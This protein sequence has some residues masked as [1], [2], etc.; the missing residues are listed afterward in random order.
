MNVF[1]NKL[2]MYYEI[3]K[4]FREDHTI[5]EI[6]RELVLNRRTVRSYLSMTEL[7]YEQ[8]ISNQSD[9]KKDLL[10]FEDFVKSRLEQFQDTST[11]QIHDWLKEK[12]E[13][14]P[15]VST[16]TIYNFVMWVRQK[17]NLP[18]VKPVR[19]Y[20]IVEELAY[21]KQAQVDFGEYNMRDGNHKRVKVWFFLIVL[22]RSRFKYVWFSDQPFTSAKAI[23]A[24]EKAFG[25]IG[26]IPD[27]IVYDQDKVFIVDEN[28]GDLILTDA[29]RAYT[30][31]RSFTLHF[32]RKADPESK[33]KI[34]NGVRYVKQ[35]FLY[36]RPF[37]NLETLN[38]EAI[39]WLGRTANTMPHNRTM[40]PPYDEWIIEKPFLTPFTVFAIPTTQ[41]IP[42]SVRKDNAISWKGNF[43]A[44]PLGT[45]KGRGSQVSVKKENNQIVISDLSGK[46]LC[47]HIIPT[48]KGQVVTN[49]DL[50]RDKSAAIEELIQQVSLMFNDP[51]SARLYLESIH[52]EKPRYIRDQLILIRQTIEKNDKETINEALCYCSKNCIYSAVDFK[53]VVKHNTRAKIQPTGLIIARNNPLSNIS[54]LN[55]SVIPAKSK[56]IDYE[57]LM[58]NKN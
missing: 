52:G 28:R 29:F 30:K 50:R 51:Q 10:D 37:Y 16:K 3:H 21:G 17:Y 38:D 56:I 54:I 35:N 47:K 45:Y 58:Q 11:A 25:F 57:N 40:K 8:F 26:G 31:E 32:C 49:T 34:E 23:I 33:G 43:Y 12:H 22:S 55:A 5:S 42:Y 9:R 27:E 44:L 1:Y 15:K 2:I 13:N 53:A 14:F 48:G 20:M 4:M 41:Q 6:S 18:K 46:E 24:H 36:N 19:E 39:A 7:Q